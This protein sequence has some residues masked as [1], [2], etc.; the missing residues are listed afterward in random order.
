VPANQHAPILPAIADRAVNE[1]SLVTFTNLAS[2]ADV[3]AQVLTYSLDSSAPAG[4]SINRQS[5]V[6]RWT[7][8]EVQGGAVYSFTVRVSD[9]GVP[10]YSDSK[11]CSVTVN[12]VNSPPSIAS[13]QAVR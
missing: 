10:T 5:G 11:T 3:P 12:K 2:D 8:S 9:N 4:A 1:G 6:F 7:P 13:I